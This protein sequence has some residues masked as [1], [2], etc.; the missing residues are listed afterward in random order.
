MS[1]I[2]A[3]TVK[4]DKEAKRQEELQEL[5]KRKRAE[6]KNSYAKYVK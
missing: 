3:S 1:N 2:Y 6:R 4:K 5:E